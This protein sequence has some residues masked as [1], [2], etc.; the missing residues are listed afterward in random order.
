MSQKLPAPWMR[1]K[2]KNAR[3]TSCSFVIF[4]ERVVK[5]YESERSPGAFY[6]NFAQLNICSTMLTNRQGSVWLNK[7]K[8]EKG[9][10]TD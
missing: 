1:T 2:Y 8:E 10:Q 7:E 5:H 6:S 3:E 9:R 4:Y